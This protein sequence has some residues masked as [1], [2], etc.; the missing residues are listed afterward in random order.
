MDKTSHKN[1]GIR[2]NEQK[3]KFW[4]V[5]EKIILDKIKIRGN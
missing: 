2:I 1:L 3:R 4:Y 5:K